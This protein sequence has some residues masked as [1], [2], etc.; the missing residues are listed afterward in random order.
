MKIQGG[1]RNSRDNEEAFY[2]SGG[3]VDVVNTVYI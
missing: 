2:E 1:T 3:V